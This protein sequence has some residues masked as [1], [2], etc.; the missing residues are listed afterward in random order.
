MALLI[1]DGFGSYSTQFNNI[2]LSQV[3]WGNNLQLDSATSTPYWRSDIKGAWLHVNQS[4]AV[5]APYTTNR[6][7]DTFPRRSLGGNHNLLTVGF[8]LRYT[9][10]YGGSLAT[11]ATMLFENDDTPQ[12]G[13]MF[14]ADGNIDV[15]RYSSPT[16]GTV[17]AS[18]TGGT[19]HLVNAIYYYEFSTKIGTSDG[20]IKLSV[21]GVELINLTGI[22]TQGDGTATTA[23]TLCFGNAD[24]NHPPFRVTDLYVRSDLTQHGD[25]CVERIIPRGDVTTT[26][27]LNYYEGGTFAEAVAETWSSDMRLYGSEMNS[28]LLFNI[29]ELHTVPVS[30]KA[31]RMFVI[32]SATARPRTVALQFKSGSSVAEFNKTF[33]G[34]IRNDE[35]IYE[36]YLEI[37]PATSS[38]FTGA[39]L[40]ALQIGLKIKD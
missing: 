33:N 27:F 30:V 13:L 22:N 20:S 16:A 11:C 9:V 15:I 37:D 3:W 17:L 18:T 32:A 7:D 8:R 40:Q 36:Q 10:P 31:L 1:I 35:R 12:I 19:H 14:K 21:N 29:N 39:A 34:V 24:Q 4:N 38:P 26:G 6:T 25:V 23:N 5:T 28:E 2:S